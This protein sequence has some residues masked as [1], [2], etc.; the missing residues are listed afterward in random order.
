MRTTWRMLCWNL[1]ST[2]KSVLN[3]LNTSTTRKY[4]RIAANRTG[5]VDP[6]QTLEWLSISILISTKLP[7]SISIWNKEKQS[8]NSFSLL[9]SKLVKRKKL[10]R[11]KIFNRTVVYINCG[12]INAGHCIQPAIEPATLFLAEVAFGSTSFRSRVNTH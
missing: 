9:I 2:R 7:N 3:C 1:F 11:N 10:V 8:I 4:P 12:S 6:D 5:G